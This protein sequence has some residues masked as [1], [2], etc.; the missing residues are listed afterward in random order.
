MILDTSVEYNSAVERSSVRSNLLRS[1]LHV[2]NESVDFNLL[3]TWFGMGKEDKEVTVSLHHGLTDQQQLTFSFDDLY[4][5]N[6][7]EF[8]FTCDQ[9]GLHTQ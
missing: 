7:G 3:T 8:T 4:A 6:T 2:A 9:R 5:Q 1:D